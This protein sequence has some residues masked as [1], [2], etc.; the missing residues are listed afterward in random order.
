MSVPPRRHP[1]PS[2]RAPR[3]LVAALASLL[4]ATFLGVGA[5]PAS[6]AP[7]DPIPRALPQFGDG[8]VR[9]TAQIGNRVYVAGSFRRVG[10]LHT[11]SA[12]VANAVTGTF[13]G[14]FPSVDG[15]VNAVVADGAGG[16]YLG[17][18]FDVVG[19]VSR[20]NLAHVLADGSVAAWAPAPDG[21]VHALALAPEGDALFVGGAFPTI[22]GAAVPD[23]AKVATATGALLPWSGGADGTVRTL[24]VEGSGLWV[25]GAFGTVGGAAHPRLARLDRT[26]GAVDPAVAPGATDGEV[27]ALVRRADGTL[28]VGGSFTTLS[29]S[30]RSGLGT[31]NAGGTAVV[32]RDGGVVGAV[33]SLSLS[34]S[35]TSLFVGG[36]FSRIRGTTRHNLAGLALS[37]WAPTALALNLEAGPVDVVLAAPNG[38][39]L[40]V[41]GSF[42]IRTG[43]PPN[44]I[45]IMALDLRT[46]TFLPFNPA[47]FEPADDRVGV[48]AMA[49]VGDR[50]FLG[51][52]FGAYDGVERPY[53]VAIDLTTGAVDPT[54]APRPNKPVHALLPSADGTTLYIGGL[55]TTVAGKGRQRLA[56]VDAVTGAPDTFNPKVDAEVMKLALAG[57]SLFVGGRFS[58]VGGL[59]RTNLARVEVATGAVRP[60]SLSVNGA[61]RSL[62]VTP[63]GRL[64]FIT[65]QFSSVGGVTR[66]GL[67]SI[68]VSTG[69]VTTWAP[70]LYRGRLMTRDLEVSPDGAAVYVVSSGGDNPPSG[71]TAVKFPTAGSGDVAP[72][73]VNRVMDTMEAVAV[74][75]DAVYIGGHLRSV[76]AGTKVRTRLAAL[77]PATG[78][79]LDWDPRASGFRGVLDL[80]LGPAGLLVGSDGTHVGHRTPSARFGLLPLAAA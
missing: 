49:L 43:A 66:N 26:T 25:G 34:P 3:P 22:G 24:L 23:L 13:E 79:G 39:T 59:P 68:S 18:D 47:L 19:G 58:T 38:T 61:V 73:W 72:V 32:G 14:G 67:A 42:D 9:A 53:L 63:D 70:N 11:G 55:F 1:Q 5:R 16:W 71:D 30:P 77:D 31:L 46:N 10:P 21:P 52:D 64:L 40:Y 29:G 65:G 75:D 76:D 20:P 78:T 74:A 35:G 36:E 51:G 45:R 37:T 28:F 80:T 69:R 12:G 41:G 54:F 6:A 33:H 62:D 2:R 27:R 56:R 60:M 57:D 4:A 50:L 7:I 17:G 48:R 44:P 15:L 8:E